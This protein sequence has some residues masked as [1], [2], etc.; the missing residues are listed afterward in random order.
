MPK[1]TKSDE[2]SESRTEARSESVAAPSK[3]NDEA[4]A[5]AERQLGP[6]AGVSDS[7]KKDLIQERYDGMVASDAQA[8]DWAGFDGKDN[9]ILG[10]LK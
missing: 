6:M 4:W 1:R 8:K 9:T 7:D 10:D 5:E 3:V 2:R